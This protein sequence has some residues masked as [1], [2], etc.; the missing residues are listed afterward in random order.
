MYSIR[1][2]E[3]EKLVT[4]QSGH[5]WDYS[6]T[7]Y[8]VYKK[9]GRRVVRVFKTKRGAKKYVERKMRDVS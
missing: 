4:R 8:V 5:H 9:Y 1:E 3:V 6:H 2:R 7:E